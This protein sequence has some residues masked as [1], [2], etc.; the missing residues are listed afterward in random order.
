MSEYGILDKFCNYVL[1]IDVNQFIVEFYGLNNP[2]YYDLLNSINKVNL[3]INEPLSFWLNLDEDN[4]NKF[5]TML[6][7]YDSNKTFELILPDNYNLGYRYEYGNKYYQLF[8]IK[9]HNDSDD[10]YDSSD[11]ND[12]NNSTSDSIDNN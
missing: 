2:S 5:I 3:L 6:E 1:N 8:R 4:K 9:N 11:D 12:C 10:N 7:N